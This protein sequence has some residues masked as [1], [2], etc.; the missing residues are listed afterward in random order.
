LTPTLF[1]CISA[2]REDEQGCKNWLELALDDCPQL[3]A[4]DVA[5]DEDLGKMKSKDWF[6]AIIKDMDDTSSEPE[7]GQG[8]DEAATS[9]DLK[10]GEAGE[11]ATSSNTDMQ[12]VGG[13]E[14]INASE[15]S[16]GDEK[17]IPTT[18]R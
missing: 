18:E 1:S 12:Q 7:A 15:C 5:Q 9:L 11:R 17:M 4:N 10:A 3:T 13:D 14:V 8:S 16:D 2:L 6:I